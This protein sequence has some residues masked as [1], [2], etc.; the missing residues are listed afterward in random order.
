MS[1][2]F[3][4]RRFIGDKIFELG[5]WIMPDP[6]RYIYLAFMHKIHAKKIKVSIDAQVKIMAE[7]TEE[8]E[9]KLSRYPSSIEIIDT[10]HDGPYYTKKPTP[11][12]G[13]IIK[14]SED[15]DPNNPIND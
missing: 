14:E 6:S 2:L 1:I 7:A 9:R 3:N 5:F 11:P 12:L 4:F 13:R 10:D 8:Y 15:D